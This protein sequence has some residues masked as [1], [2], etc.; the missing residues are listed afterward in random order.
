MSAFAICQ[1]RT[2]EFGPEIGR[3]LEE[4]DATL[5]PYA[6]EFRV[7]GGTPEV[8]EEPWEGVVVVIE[9]P[10]SDRARAW[11]HSDA[12]QRIL[13]LRTENSDSSAILVE[14]V[15]PGYRAASFASQASQP[16]A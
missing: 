3:Y 9:F 12:Y 14:G 6:G 15:E 5:E 7:H 16:A 13:P 10:D 4:I 2:V 1:L 8:A 11:Y